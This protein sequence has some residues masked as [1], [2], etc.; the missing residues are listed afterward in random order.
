MKKTVDCAHIPAL[1][2]REVTLARVAK[3]S[4]RPV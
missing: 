1:P 3:G 4:F 2:V